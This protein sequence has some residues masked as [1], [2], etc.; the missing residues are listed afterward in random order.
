MATNNAFAAV[1]TLPKVDKKTVNPRATRYGVNHIWD[2]PT[3][4]KDFYVW[5]I[6]ANTV[7]PFRPFQGEVIRDLNDKV[8]GVVERMPA[9]QILDMY[10]MTQFFTELEPLAR[11]NDEDKAQKITAVLANPEPC[12]KYPAELGYACATCSLKDSLTAASD[13]IKD[14][15]KDDTELRKTANDCLLLLRNGLSKA[16]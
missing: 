10:N 1:D 5:R 4:A 8:L 7:F 16:T 3:S 12:G 2:V 9:D 6:P 13:R 11:L 14:A 15:F